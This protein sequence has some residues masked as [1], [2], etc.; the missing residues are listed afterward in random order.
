MNEQSEAFKW[1]FEN[2]M[3]DEQ[4]DKVR[5]VIRQIAELSAQAEPL[6]TEYIAAGDRSLREARERGAMSKLSRQALEAQEWPEGSM[7]S[8]QQWLDWLLRL[9]RSD[10]MIIAERVDKALDRSHRCFAMNH[11]NLMRE[12][13]A[14][15]DQRWKTTL[16][17]KRYRLAWLSAR[18]YRR[19][20]RA[21]VTDYLGSR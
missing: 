11:D 17:M 3:T 10:Q 5:A 7:P 1:L 12:L 13:R 19:N 14:C 8:P 6:V 18:R 4:R 15:E 16:R 9:D 21:M 2:Q 20:V